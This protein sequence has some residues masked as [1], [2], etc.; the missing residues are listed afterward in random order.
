M[1]HKLLIYLLSKYVWNSFFTLAG[2]AISGDDV[3]APAKGTAELTGQ[4]RWVA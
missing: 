2:P 3:V 4:W 1:N